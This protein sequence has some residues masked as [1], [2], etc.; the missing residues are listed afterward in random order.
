MSPLRTTLPD[1][2]GNIHDHALPARDDV[3]LARRLHGAGVAEHAADGA[4]ADRDS[5]DDEPA[6]GRTLL[7]SSCFGSSQNQRRNGRGSG[8]SQDGEDRESERF[9][10]G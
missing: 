10:R 5:A 4:D 1:V 2:D 6:G 9:T 7:G 3:D 8:Q